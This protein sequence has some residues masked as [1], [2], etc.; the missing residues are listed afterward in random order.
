MVG[1]DRNLR[2]L[3]VGTDQIHHYDLSETVRIAKTTVRIVASFRRDDAR[4]RGSIA[5]K[6]GQRRTDRT[7]HLLHNVTKT[8]VAMALQWREAIVLEDIQGIRCLYQKGNGQGGGFGV[9]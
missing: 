1:V 3:T 2:N 4:T 5:S 8:I 7:G 6:Y 9:G